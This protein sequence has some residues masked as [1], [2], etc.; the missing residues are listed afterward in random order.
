MAQ[1]LLLLAGMYISPLKG[2]T[3]SEKLERK[4]KWNGA[5]ECL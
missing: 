5:K 1:D 3:T 2:H 4:E